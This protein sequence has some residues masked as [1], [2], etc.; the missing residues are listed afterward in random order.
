MAELLLTAHRAESQL[1]AHS[2]FPVDDLRRDLGLTEPSFETVF[3]PTGFDPTGF[4]PTGFDPT[5]LTTGNM[6]T[7]LRT[8]CCGWAPRATTAS[9]R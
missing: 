8:P 2:D 5:G 6:A 7:F 3:D 4:D 9:S 1:L